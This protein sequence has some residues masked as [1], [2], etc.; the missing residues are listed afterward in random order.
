[1]RTKWGIVS[2]VTMAAAVAILILTAQSVYA[3]PPPRS[4]IVQLDWVLFGDNEDSQAYLDLAP[5]ALNG[6]Q[7]IT[8]TLNLHGLCAGTGDESAIIVDQEGWKYVSLNEY[9]QKCKDGIQ[10]VTIPLSDFPNLDTSAPLTGSFHVRFWHNK[11][12][13]VDIISIK[14]NTGLSPNRNTVPLNW[15]L[16]GNNG[17]SQAYLDVAPD[18]LEGLQ[19]IS[20]T[21]NLHGRCALD[22]D[23]SAVVFDQGVDWKYVSL[24]KYGTNCKDG[25]QTVNIAISDFPNL[26]TNAPLTGKF[27]VRFWN[28][29]PFLF[30]IISVKWNYKNGH[31]PFHGGEN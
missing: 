17:D 8:L 27:H 9:G 24:S 14:F 25:R 21:Y 16:F 19:S 2:V 3:G 20:L 30:E 7:S 13:L 15:V 26:D 31:K 12:F 10:S 4:N 23:A 18:T 1:M 5:D 28:D 6:M 22:G 29:Q 11:P